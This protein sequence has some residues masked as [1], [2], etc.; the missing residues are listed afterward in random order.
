VVTRFR[1]KSFRTPQEPLLARHQWLV[2]GDGLRD[3]VRLLHQRR[4]RAIAHGAVT[5]PVCVVKSQCVAAVARLGLLHIL[6]NLGFHSGD[7]GSRGGT[8]DFGGG[9]LDRFCFVVLGEGLVDPLSHFLV[10]FRALGCE[11]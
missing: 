3:G 1:Q 4:A 8:G 7:P 6:D 11:E 9:G 10:W 2:R 5:Y